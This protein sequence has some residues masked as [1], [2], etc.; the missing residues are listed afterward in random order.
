MNE[1]EESTFGDRLRQIRQKL[2][3]SQKNF[4]AKLNITGPALSEFENN[5]YKPGYEFFYMI[6][7][8]FKVNLYYL[9]FGEGEMFTETM[10][11]LHGRL[12][13]AAASSKELRRFLY[14]LE[15][16][17]LVQYNTLSQFRRFYMDEKETIERDLKAF[18]EE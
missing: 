11:G 3:M 4:A 10:G 13:E 14:Y 2:K 1:Q 17:P 18:T 6:V 12:A 5:K 7:K 8:E 9:I 16:S 15:N